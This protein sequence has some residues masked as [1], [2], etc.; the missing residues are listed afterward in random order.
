MRYTC[1]GCGHE[2]TTDGIFAYY[3]ECPVCRWVGPTRSE[4]ETINAIVLVTL[5]HV[6]HEEQL[7]R[8]ADAAARGAAA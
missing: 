1:E 3:Y 5:G 6:R 8:R 7:H 2:G 4:R